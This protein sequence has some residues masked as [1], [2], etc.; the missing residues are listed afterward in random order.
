MRETSSAISIHRR[1]PSTASDTGDLI[2]EVLPSLLRQAADRDELLSHLLAVSEFLEYIQRLVASTLDETA[3]VHD[4]PIGIRRIRDDNMPSFHEKL[5]HVIGNHFVFS[6]NPVLPHEIASALL[7]CGILSQLARSAIELLRSEY[8][9]VILL[10]H[11]L[12]ILGLDLEELFRTLD[13]I[14]EQHP[15]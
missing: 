12:G 6:D 4:Q 15:A 13:A 8:K 5:G 1:V 2:A 11:L 9:L 3:G 10:R 7:R 14:D